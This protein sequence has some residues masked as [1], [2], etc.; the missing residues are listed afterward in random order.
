MGT[1]DISRINFNPEKHY[2]S[3]RMQ[4]GRVLTDDDWNEN[5]RISMEDERRTVNDIIGS[6]GT[7][8]DGFRIDTVAEDTNGFI[9]FT[10]GEGALYLGGLRLEMDKQESYRAQQDWLQQPAD[11]D[12]APA[13]AG[14]PRYDLVYLEAWQQAV[15]AVEDSSLFEVALGG[16]DTTTR[17]RNMRRVHL[18]PDIGFSSCTDA[19]QQ[20]K[21]NWENLQLGKINGENELGP[22]TTL[23]VSFEGTGVPGDPCNPAAAGGYLG[24]EN[25]AIRVQIVDDST[26]KKIT[27]GFDNASPLY[28][29][30]LGADGKTITMLTEPKDQYHWPLSGQVVEL[31]PWSAVLP[32][33]EKIAEISGYLS[34]VD[35]SYDPDKHQFTI[36]DHI[37]PL[38]QEYYF[39]RV[40]NRGTDLASPA[41]IEL[42]A[43]SVTL[44]NT[45]LVISFTG[46]NWVA[47]DY[48]VIAARP[49]SPK[50]VV[51]WELEKGIFH[52][53]IRRFF[54]PL[55]VIKW[56]NAGN[57]P[58]GEVVHDCRK[59]FH[60]L[61]DLDGCCTYTV[62][63]GITSKGDFNSIQEAVDSLPE[64]GGRICVLPGEHKAN[65]TLLKKKQVRITGC[66]E[67]TIVRPGPDNQK[68]PVFSIRNSQKIQIDQ[69]TIYTCKGTGIEVY[70]DPGSDTFSEQITIRDNR[71]LASVH[72]VYVQMQES[73]KGENDIK[74]IGNMI[75]MVDQEGGEA[76]VFC[77]ADQVLIEY[78]RI[79]VIQ[80]NDGKDP[81]YPTHP[82]D[83]GNKDPFNPCFDFQVTYEIGYPVEILIFWLLRYLYLYIP[84][85]RSQKHYLALGGI[86]I[87]NFSERVRILNNLIIGGRGNGITL[88]HLPGDIH[89]D[90]K[91][92]GYAFI[93]ETAIEDNDI[94]QMGLNGIATAMDRMKNESSVYL[95]DLTISRNKIRYCAHQLFKTID[96]NPDQIAFGGIILYDCEEGIIRENRIE[97][98]G[99]QQPEPVCG[100][101]VFYGEKLDISDNHIVNNGPFP[102]LSSLAGG[103][104]GGI[105]VKMSFKTVGFYG[106]KALENSGPGT[107]N[108]T[109]TSPAVVAFDT[110]PAVTVHD[111]IVVQP[112]GFA[113]LL[114]AFGPVSVLGNQ[115]TSL[116]TDPTNRLSWFAST[117][118]IINLGISK[119]LFAMT[120]TQM[121]FTDYRLTRM[122]NDPA[123]QQFILAY[124]YLP[125]GKV[126]F[127]GNQTTLDMRYPSLNVCLSSQMIASRDDI[128]FN[129]NQ[130]ECTSLVVVTDGVG[131]TDTVIINT[132]LFAPSV[133]SN[134]NRFTDGLSRT[135][136]SLLSFGFMA[137]ATGNQA[138]N[139]IVVQGNVNATVDT[140]NTVLNDS[141]CRSLKKT[142]P[143][144][145][146]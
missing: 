71:I 114:G 129:N 93:Y 35:A 41:A 43:G 104:R 117:V 63:N 109:G 84:T 15:S 92:S 4:Q 85:G 83:P 39:L 69:L 108:T 20:L 19:W 64:K 79:V 128:A 50:Q 118:C 32:N 18:A 16:P 21:K 9:D 80:G 76:A 82:D 58:K 45:G 138:T 55:A 87:G 54:A 3:V 134:D 126:M 23:T 13:L 111:N 12:R 113:L 51:P 99:R 75:G 119:D 53:G 74:I 123:A 116:G 127:S 132:A 68:D 125:G 141:R 144:F 49:E 89:F 101:F 120:Y 133:R 90:R 107:P 78:N 103:N 77:L 96:V 27:W 60:P 10:I 67:Q 38:N 136:F 88:G 48:W 115:F 2:A 73:R 142:M 29:V 11:L 106:R 137:T 97:Q 5:E 42:V 17:L 8:G 110:L 1:F 62:G 124:Q 57:A 31:L 40:W 135:F 100:I 70:D 61:T 30:T 52:H 86:Q 26:S 25:Q 28:R 66:G 47:G 94:M 6:F 65:V 112:V 146:K 46:K 36:Q 81:D 44:G 37:R 145:K 139:C 7:S 122:L 72:A 131:F 59:K 33:G 22:D 24:A 121:N 140:Q 105:V 34:K 98:N 130:S 102:D 56:T 95:H 14:L 143:L 91:E